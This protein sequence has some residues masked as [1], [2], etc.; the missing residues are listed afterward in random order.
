MFSSF[1][2]LIKIKN[3]PSSWDFLNVDSG[4][5]CAI[6]HACNVFYFS[7]SMQSSFGASTSDSNYLAHVSSASSPRHA[8]HS[9]EWLNT[10]ER[11]GFCV[12]SFVCC[13]EHNSDSDSRPRQTR[14]R[15]LWKSISIQFSSIQYNTIQ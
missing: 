9:I 7:R 3:N 2:W 4:P 13:T 5:V 15:W 6:L 8:I 12:R 14:S 1:L 11:F 10:A